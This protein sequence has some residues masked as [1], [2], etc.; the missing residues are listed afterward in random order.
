MCKRRELSLPRS[1]NLLDSCIVFA[2]LI[3]D[4]IKKYCSVYLRLKINVKLCVAAIRMLLSYWIAQ[5]WSTHKCVII[6]FINMSWRNSFST[7]QS[8]ESGFNITCSVTRTCHCWWIK[9][10]N[11][12]FLPHNSLRWDLLCN[13]IISVI[14]TIY[15]RLK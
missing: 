4:W 1:P 6:A 12:G 13:I 3:P 15:N 5:A 9:I 7:W 8:S 11:P 14:W 2:I 10:V